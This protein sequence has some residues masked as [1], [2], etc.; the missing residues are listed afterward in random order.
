MDSLRIPLVLLA[1]LLLG[2][3]AAVIADG[4]NGTVSTTTTATTTTATTTTT[5]KAP[6]AKVCDVCSCEGECACAECFCAR[7]NSCTGS[8]E[9]GVVPKMKVQVVDSDENLLAVR[10]LVHELYFS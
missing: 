7:G 9:V 3:R 4:Q 6:V 8:A 2:L 1:A 10:N 5:A